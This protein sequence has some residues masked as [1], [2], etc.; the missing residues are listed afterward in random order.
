[1]GSEVGPY[2]DS[3]IWITPR[4]PKTRAYERPVISR[5]TP[6]ST[7][8]SIA[9]LAVGVLTSN[10]CATN[11]IVSIGQSINAP[12]ILETVPD[13]WRS[14]SSWRTDSSQSINLGPGFNL[15]HVT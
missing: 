13:Q 1:I 12:V 15:M 8:R 11:D 10:F 3:R 7:R 2:I 9:L 4:A 5:R 6:I 14:D